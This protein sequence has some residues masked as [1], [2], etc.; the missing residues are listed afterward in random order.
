MMIGS[1][2]AAYMAGTKTG[3]DWPERVVD[4]WLRKNELE[5][6]SSAR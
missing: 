1:L 3:R 2:Y 5:P 6:H 4:T